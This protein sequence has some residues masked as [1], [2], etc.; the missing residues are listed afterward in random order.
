MLK[1]CY[2]SKQFKYESEK[3]R[4]EISHIPQFECKVCSKKFSFLSALKRHLKQH[5]R[6]SSV[7]CNDC[8]RTF[9]DDILLKRH[10][11]Y[12]HKG[13]YICS[14]CDAK[15]NSDLALIS[16]LKTHKPKIERRYKCSYSGCDKSFNFS[17]HLKHH[18]LTHSNTKQHYCKICG[19]GFI[20]AHHL[21]SH[22][23]THELENCLPSTEQNSDKKFASETHYRKQYLD[24]H[25][26]G[27][28]LH[29]DN[30]S[31]SNFDINSNSMTDKVCPKCDRSIKEADEEHECK[32]KEVTQDLSIDV[33]DDIETYNN[34]IEVF[35]NCKSVLGKCIANE[36]SSCLCSQIN[37]AYNFYDSILPNDDFEPVKLK[38]VKLKGSLIDQS[39]G[40]INMCEG[41]E[42]SK[43]VNESS[44]IPLECTKDGAIKIKDL[45]DSDI[46]FSMKKTSIDLNNI[47]YGCKAALGK[48]IVS[49]SG[50]ISE[51][52]L[53]AKMA[54]D[55]QQMISQQMDEITPRPSMSL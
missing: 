4:H 9:L 25:L 3:K 47:S 26:R 38:E 1:C 33:K 32:L 10:M 21:K 51:E 7:K 52:C 43:N 50:D 39:I 45:F 16:H 20:Q 46:D 40:S 15:F 30:S 19:K 42:C 5:E 13:T 29:S 34:N 12:A 8:G 27:I 18:L 53:C 23:R 55:D 48:C 44:N 49:G 24:D 11:T 37:E 54:M 17:H 22:L 41:C 31:D 28:T 35:K 6:T 2:C 36:D 14:K